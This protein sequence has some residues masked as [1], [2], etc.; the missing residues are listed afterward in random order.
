M[1]AVISMLYAALGVGVAELLLQGMI[2]VLSEEPTKLH[3][4][5]IS[6][7]V[8]FVISVMFLEPLRTRAKV[9][10]GLKPSEAK[11]G[12]IFWGLAGPGIALLFI[13]LTEGIERAIQHNPG[14]SILLFLVLLFVPGFVTL[15]WISGTRREHRA[16]GYGLVVG[17]VT[18]FVARGA[19]WVSAGQRARILVS[20]TRSV[21]PLSRPQQVGYRRGS[22]LAAAVSRL[23]GL[24]RE[25]RSKPWLFP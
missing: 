15:G 2:G 7:A 25:G 22:T 6:L 24:K 20:R 16:A 21:P 18:D 8:F 14:G 5:E 11:R 1:S 12:G 23:I 17:A 9:V 19:L 10:I 4:L 13:I 3:Y